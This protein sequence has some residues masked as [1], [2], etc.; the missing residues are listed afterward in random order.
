MRSGCGAVGRAVAS[1]N[2][3]PWFESSHQQGYF[4]INCIQKLKFDRLK[5]VS[6]GNK[7]S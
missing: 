7:D 1:D 4:T 6:D 3:D 2:R 5:F